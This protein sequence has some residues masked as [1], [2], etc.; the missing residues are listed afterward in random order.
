MAKN[1][2]GADDKS[3]CVLTFKPSSQSAGSSFHTSEP[4]FNLVTLKKSRYRNYG[5]I[6]CELKINKK[7]RIFLLYTRSS[8]VQ[9]HRHGGLNEKKII[10]VNLRLAFI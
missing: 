5:F 1:G 9:Q 8:A 2:S 10:K 4:Y 6:I 7:T 3:T